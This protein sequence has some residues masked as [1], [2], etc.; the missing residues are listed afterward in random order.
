MVSKENILK[1]NH[2]PLERIDFSTSWFETEDEMTPNSLL[3]NLQHKLNLGMKF[4]DVAY[5]TFSTA[6]QTFW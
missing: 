1:N 4:E 3:S 6:D 2:F 5:D